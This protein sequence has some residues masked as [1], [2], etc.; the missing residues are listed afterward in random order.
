MLDGAS[1]FLDFDGTLVAIAERPDAV[2]VDERLDRSMV[3]LAAVLNGRI[4]IVSGR[5]LAEVDRLLARGRFA[6]GGSHG[7]ELRWPDGR[8]QSPVRPDAMDGIVKEMR[9]LQA[10]HPG[11]IVEE[12]PFGAA[13]HYRQAP[14]AEAESR[15]LAARLADL[16]GLALQTGKM[17]F[18]IKAA[19]ADKGSALDAL[20]QD[21]LFAGTR[22]IFIGDDHTDEAGFRAAAALGGAGILV[23]PERETAAGYRLEGVAETLDWLDAAADALA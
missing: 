9:A 21:A 23:G 3:R 7:L 16:P 5:A 12:K 15:A 22:P 20:M 14:T 13:L 2:V 8:L 1:L 10:I 11:V 6:V 18:E 19:G 4:A 17:V